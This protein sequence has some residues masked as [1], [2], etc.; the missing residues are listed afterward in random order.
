MKKLN[1]KGFTVS[2]ILYALLIGF[3]LFLLAALAMFSSSNTLISGCNDD[4]KRDTT[5]YDMR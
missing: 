1:N 2:A 4:I 3:L 5:K